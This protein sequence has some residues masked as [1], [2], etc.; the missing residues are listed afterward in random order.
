MTALAQALS[1]ALLDFV[2]QGLLVA[3]LL[4]I[5]L[6]ILRNR[7]ARARYA[8]SC[9]ALG[10]M[11]ALPA[12]TAYLIYVAPDALPAAGWVSAAPQATRLVR[13]ASSVTP[14]DLSAWVERW[15]LPAW[16]LGVL[17]FSLR[18]VWAA[19]QVAAV[20]RR[21]QAPE[22]AIL[23]AVTN[24]C[25]RM[26]LSRTVRLLITAAADCPSVVGWIRPVLLLPASTLAGLTAEQLEAVLAH[27][28]AHILRYDYLVNMLQTA[29][30]TLLFYHPAV[31]W[32]SS[33]IR[34][35]RELCCDDLAVECCGDALCYAR[36]LTK[37]E[38]LRVPAP[39]LALGSTGG[40]LMYRIRRIMGEVR[41]GNSPSKLPGILALS[42][43][44]ICLALNMPWARGQQPEKPAAVAADTSVEDDPGVRVDLKG[45]TV[46][47]REPVEYPAGAAEKGIIGTVVVEATL[48]A[49]GEVTDARVL[50]GPSELR[51]AALESVLHWHFTPAAGAP[52]VSIT[53]GKPAEGAVRQHSAKHA[54]AGN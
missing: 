7:S 13:A 22:A 1:A 49:A 34:H 44:L 48:G 47:H 4:W 45:A 43:G 50:S 38:R 37:L 30:E 8:V 6:F 9:L 2:W 17:I 28:L 18:L 12:V 11:A 46:M 29:V 5:A 31:W 39:R 16:F 32:A 19:R 23:D 35:E 21:S 33:R 3:V 26:K 24:L 40:S 41:P 10:L 15:A 25:A 51:K 20:R 14:F 42:L 52:Q 27:E 53:F 54:E 36:A